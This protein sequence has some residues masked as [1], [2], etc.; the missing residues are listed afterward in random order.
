MTFTPEYNCTK[1]V[2]FVNFHY[3]LECLSLVNRQILD[4]QWTNTLAYYER[5]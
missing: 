3:K 4:L 1:H 5:S 2:I